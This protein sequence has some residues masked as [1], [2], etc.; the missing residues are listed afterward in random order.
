MLSS[1]TDPESNITEST[2]VYED[3]C[4]NV[5]LLVS[6]VSLTQ[7][8]TPAIER[9]GN[10]FKGFQNFELK[11]KDR[12]LPHLSYMCHVHSTAVTTLS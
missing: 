8:L 3:T 11:D 12:I 4:T 2:S 10:T 7:Q 1:E 6:L 9:K 5:D